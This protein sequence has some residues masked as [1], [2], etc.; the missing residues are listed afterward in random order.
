MQPV[1]ASVPVTSPDPAAVIG[2]IVIVG[3]GATGDFA[4]RDN[5]LAILG[6][7][8]WRFVA[9]FTG[10]AAQIAQTGIEWRFDGTNWIE[11]S[12]NV[13]EI[14]VSG[15]KV[16]GAQQPDIVAPTG[17]TTPDSEARTAISAILGTLRAHG[18]IAGAQ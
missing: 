4:G 18:L 2:D 13:Q 10:M 15:V 17:G 7:N 16:V 8:G 14:L 11:G 6:E 5:A 12:Q 3:V 1:L 9:A